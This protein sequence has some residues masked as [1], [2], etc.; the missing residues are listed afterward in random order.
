MATSSSGSPNDGR[1]DRHRPWAARDRNSS[2][3][4]GRDGTTERVCYRAGARAGAAMSVLDKLEVCVTY[5]AARG[6]GR[7]RGK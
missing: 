6:Y 7:G 5:D 2:G 1:R 3:H 4:R